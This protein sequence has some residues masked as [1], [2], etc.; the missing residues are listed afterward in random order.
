MLW[1]SSH[2]PINSKINKPHCLTHFMWSALSCCHKRTIL[3]NNKNVNV[4]DEKFSTKYHRTKLSSKYNRRFIYH[5]QVRFT[6]VV[7]SCFKYHISVNLIHY[8]SGMK[9]IILR[10]RKS[11]LTKS[12]IAY[13]LNANKRGSW[14]A[15]YQV[16]YT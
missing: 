9:T 8:I 1:F 11:Y 15:A 3:E 10:D 12:N 6:P 16:Q 4:S 14:V 7:Q 13:D 5:D 2:S